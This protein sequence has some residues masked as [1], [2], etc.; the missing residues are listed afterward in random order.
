LVT[1]ESRF[2]ESEDEWPGPRDPFS[3]KAGCLELDEPEPELELWLGAGLLAPVLIGVAVGD[4][5]T[6]LAGDG[7]VVW[8]AVVAV[9]VLFELMAWVTWCLGVARRGRWCRAAGRSRE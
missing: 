3:P 8:T 7:L 9:G 1:R 6:G 4:G 2:Q 5:V